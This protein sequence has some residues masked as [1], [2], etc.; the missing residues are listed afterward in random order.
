MYFEDGFVSKMAANVL[1]Y[2]GCYC[3]SE[4]KGL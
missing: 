2:V 3:M 1:K 4:L